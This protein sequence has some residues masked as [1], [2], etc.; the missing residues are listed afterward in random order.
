M[1]PD[2]STTKVSPL[3]AA[4][5]AFQGDLPH[6]GKDN[7]AKVPGRD[8]GRGYEYSYADLATINQTVLP[9]LA[10]HGLSW[11][12]RPTLDEQGRFVLA[13]TLAHVG[14]D[15]LTGAY[16]L[17]NPG[18]PQ[19]VGSAITYARRYCICAVTGVAP[20]EDDDGA[21]A[22]AAARQA[23]DRAAETP[24]PPPQP[25]A[26]KW[27]EFCAAIAACADHDS[28]TELRLTWN[29]QGVLDIPYTAEGGVT[30]DQKIGARREE[31]RAGGVT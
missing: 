29:R 10:K 2:V 26:E 19:A 11:A 4:L 18:N 15:E 6:I 23:Q 28:L 24:P 31:L 21:A 22:T 5:V 1:S 17:G 3:A 12:T 27:A 20:D 13:Y 25:P 8:G 9:L 7:T 16:P 30:L 14:G